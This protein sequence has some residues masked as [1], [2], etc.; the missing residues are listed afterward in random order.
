MRGIGISMN[1]TA[2]LAY[3]AASSII[4][5]ALAVQ[6]LTTEQTTQVIALGFEIVKV[7]GALVAIIGSIATTVITMLLLKNQK[8]NKK[9]LTDKIDQNTE[10]SNA[11]F[12]VANG[13]NEK[14][15]ASVE[16]S[17]KVLEALKKES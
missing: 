2:L 5:T 3:A 1:I 8:A 6:Q 14:I 12:S 10:L 17:E 15:K 7:I 9:A 13:H 4:G 11:A 16:L